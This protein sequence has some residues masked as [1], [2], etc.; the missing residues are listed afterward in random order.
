MKDKTVRSIFLR[1]PVFIALCIITLLS[2]YNKSNNPNSTTA[3]S[4]KYAVFNFKENLFDF[5]IINN[6][7]TV[8]HNFPFSNTGKVP[9]IINDISTSCG[10]TIV[11]F[12]KKPIAT[13]GHGVITV[14]FSK[15]HDP[16]LHIK[17]IIIKANT[18]DPY[19]VLHIRAV[20]KS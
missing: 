17:Q 9:L 6:G 2:C 4:E 5:G 3:K 7:D 18:A 15:H 20:T 8:T 14:Q 13:N 12:S 19:T 1:L 11:E 16:G 10:C